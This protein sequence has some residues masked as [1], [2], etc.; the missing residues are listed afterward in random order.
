MSQRLQKA[1]SKVEVLENRGPLVGVRFGA[2]RRLSWTRHCCKLVHEGNPRP[3]DPRRTSGSDGECMLDDW[4][5]LQRPCVC[6][7][8][9]PPVSQESKVT[10]EPVQLFGAE[11]GNRGWEGNG[12][13]M[14]FVILSED[15]KTPGPSAARIH[16]HG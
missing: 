1:I 2:G 12:L 5:E 7:A 10:G 6:R 11:I 4:P 15:Q 14:D 16:H 9:R 3:R 8:S 13:K